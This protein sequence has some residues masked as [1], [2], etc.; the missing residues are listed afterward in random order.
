MRCNIRPLRCPC[1]RAW[2]LEFLILHQKEVDQSSG[3]RLFEMF[4]VCS[5]AAN[6][7]WTTLGAVWG[8]PG[9]HL[10]RVIV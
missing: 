2:E 1:G 6:Q 4:C 9:V 8:D 10:A 3:A 5:R 7:D